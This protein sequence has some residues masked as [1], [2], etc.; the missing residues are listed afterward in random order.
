MLE[1]LRTLYGLQELD[2]NL[3]RAR[4]EVRRL[5]EE[6]ARRRK[7]IDAKIATRDELDQQAHGYAT[8]IKEI[9]D[10]TTQQRQRLR[11]LDGQAQ[12]SRGDAALL[13]AFQHEMRSLRR[14]IGE[15]EDEGLQLV[16]SRDEIAARR[17]VLQDEIDDLETVFAE[18]AANVER[19]L[20]EAQKRIDELEAERKQR[21]G[22]NLDASVVETYER[23]LEAREGVAMCRLIDRTCQGC[24]MEV[25]PN[26]K[27]RLARGGELVQC[28][29]CDRIL[30][31][32][33][34]VQ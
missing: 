8:R 15:A 3:F 21:M 9:E 22:D 11:K 13:A 7:D 4:E 28:Q 1:T 14:E 33:Q 34:Q 10:L 6:R 31:L 32:D 29:S 25:P 18:Y 24:Y 16:E 26:V 2:A 19:E 5:P 23:L 20:A 27:V 12:S 30:F 17:K